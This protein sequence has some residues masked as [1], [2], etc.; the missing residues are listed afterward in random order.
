VFE[1]EIPAW[2]V[3]L[4]IALSTVLFVPHH[5]KRTQS[6]AITVTAVPRLVLAAMYAYTTFQ[7][8]PLEQRAFIVRTTLTAWML[9][10]IMAFWTFKWPQKQ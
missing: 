1:Y 6:I 3:A 9:L 5:Y 10:E 2:L 4:L 8:L 7:P